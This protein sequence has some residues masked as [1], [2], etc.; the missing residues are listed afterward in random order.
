L[1]YV[2]LGIFFLP[3]KNILVP[4]FFLVFPNVFVQAAKYFTFKKSVF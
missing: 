4:K 2:Y 1:Q 3:R